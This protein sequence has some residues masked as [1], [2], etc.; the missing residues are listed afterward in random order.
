MP[1]NWKRMNR[2][3]HYWG[4]LVVALPV[5]K[6]TLI[7]YILMRLLNSGFRVSAYQ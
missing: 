1:M 2:K 7:Q 6:E 3:A 5:L 4:G